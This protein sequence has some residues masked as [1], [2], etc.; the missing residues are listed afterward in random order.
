MAR[1]NR[2]FLQRAVRFL[3]GEAGIRQIL[4]IGTGIPTAGNV[5]EIAGPIAPGHQGGRGDANKHRRRPQ[6]R[7]FAERDQHSQREAGGKQD[8]G[9]VPQPIRPR[10][11]E[12][13][14]RSF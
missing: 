6:R 14:G 13:R 10:R 9:R 12:R 1:Q 7:Q 5:H 4:D 8:N 2:A 3:V 11:I